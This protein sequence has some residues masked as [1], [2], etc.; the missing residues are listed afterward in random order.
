MSLAAFSHDGAELFFAFG[1]E[2]FYIF[3]DFEG[4]FGVSAQVAYGS[5]KVGTAFAQGLTMGRA[6]AFERFAVGLYSAFTHCGTS[7]DKGGA[8]GFAL[9]LCEG[10]GYLC[11]IVAVNFD[12]AQPH[13]RYLAA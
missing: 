1:V 13:A 3:E 4:A 9:S 12:N 5:G 2:F 8:H 6:L 11:G 7:Q 10:F